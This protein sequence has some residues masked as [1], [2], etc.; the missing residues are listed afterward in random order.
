MVA[1]D[2]RETVCAPQRGDVLAV[3]EHSTVLAARRGQPTGLCVATLVI[4]DTDRQWRPLRVCYGRNVGRRYG[5]S[6]TSPPTRLAVSRKQCGCVFVN[7]GYG[8]DACLRLRY[9]VATLLTRTCD[10]VACHVLAVRRGRRP[11]QGWRFSA[12]NMAVHDFV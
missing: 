9:S 7:S 12:N 1:R 2:H 10:R 6:R 8:A 4:A 3:R 5:A 11:L